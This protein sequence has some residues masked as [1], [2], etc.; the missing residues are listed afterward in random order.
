MVA[1]RDA[2]VGAVGDRRF[3]GAA[4]GPAPWPKLAAVI[5]TGIV[6]SAAGASAG[7]L[8]LAAIAM[9][10]LAAFW[11]TLPKSA[12]IPPLPRW[13]AIPMIAWFVAML[14]VP[15]L[16]GAFDRN[17]IAIGYTV[18]FILWLQA[19]LWLGEAFG[20]AIT[21]HEARTRTGTG[22]RAVAAAVVV[23]GSVLFSVLAYAIAADRDGNGEAPATASVSVPSGH[24]PPAT[25]TAGP[26]T[27][28]WAQFASAIDRAC[29]LNYNS[30][31][32][33]QAWVERT[34]DAESWTN[35]E[36]LAA[37]QEIWAANQRALAAD[38][39]AL[40][41]PPAKAHLL[42]SWLSNVVHRGE[43]MAFM[44]D[45]NRHG[46]PKSVRI[47]SRRVSRLKDEADLLGRD[48]G[49]RICTS[50]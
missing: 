20:P 13:I 47:A 29:A 41:A 9:A 6:L 40:G 12:F 22:Q 8:A 3:N 42:D 35:A 1:V 37:I 14:F 19:G 48:Y 15:V 36:T 16:L 2:D 25:S 50:N 5:L 31:L 10:T 27:P 30:S 4:A 17:L 11:L 26:M 44:A 43:L 45:S 49:L 32:A 34:A 38:V 33:K 7:G 39:R 46:D 23:A 24:Y 21:E 18:G 28:E